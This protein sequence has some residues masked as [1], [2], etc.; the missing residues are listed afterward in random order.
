[1]RRT[2]ALAELALLGPALLFMTALFV[3][4]LQPPGLEPAHMAQQIVQWYAGRTHLGL[5]LFLGTCP[6]VV[7]VVGSV[8]L[9]RAWRTDAELRAASLE[10]FTLI[11]AQW[12]ALLIAAATVA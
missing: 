2:L 7:L 1:M 3:R 6:F 11:R 4:N 5:W 8:A 10:T 12:A 9:L